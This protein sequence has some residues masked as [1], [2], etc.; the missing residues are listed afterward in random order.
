MEQITLNVCLASPIGKTQNF[1]DPEIGILSF[2]RAQVLL[3]NRYR[4]ERYN[5]SRPAPS[6]NTEFVFP[7]A[8]GTS[9]RVRS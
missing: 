2:N 7:G 5:L 4:I 3:G 6:L 9:D 1:V 8:Q